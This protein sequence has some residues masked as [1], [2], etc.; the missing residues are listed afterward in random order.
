[1]RE[2][3]SRWEHKFTETDGGA[4]KNLLAQLYLDLLIIK[5]NHPGMAQSVIAAFLKTLKAWEVRVVQDPVDSCCIA[6][7]WPR[8]C[9]HVPERHTFSESL[10]PLP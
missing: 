4:D 6:F 1:M 3:F 7:L 8:V 5:T 10:P 2:R 9:P